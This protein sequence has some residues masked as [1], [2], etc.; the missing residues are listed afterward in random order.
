MSSLKKIWM[1]ILNIGTGLQTTQ[2]EIM[3]GD[4]IKGEVGFLTFSDCDKIEQN[5]FET[6][7]A[8][9]KYDN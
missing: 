1:N 8:F 3:I 5:R 9:V 4:K 6:A 2:M 7:R